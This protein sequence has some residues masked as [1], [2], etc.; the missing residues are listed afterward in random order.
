MLIACCSSS[1][2]RVLDLLPARRS[3]SAS[4]ESFLSFLSYLPCGSC[5]FDLVRAAHSS[6]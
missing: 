6:T 2:H 5:V 3:F 4:Y 1:A